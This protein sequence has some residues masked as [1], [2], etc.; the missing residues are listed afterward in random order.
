MRVNA[1]F[2]RVLA[3]SPVPL[4]LQRGGLAARLQDYSITP[5]SSILALCVM[6]LMRAA[7]ITRASGRGWALEIETFLDPVNWHRADRRV[8]F[9][10]PKKSRYS[11]GQ[12]VDCRQTDISVR[13][14]AGFAGVLT[15]SP[16]PLPLQRGGLAARLQYYRP[17]NLPGSIYRKN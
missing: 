2:A 6:L 17:G 12:I 13:V 5:V 14:N 10:G 15:L 16:V 7:S 9:L 1:G 4:P 11:I 8:P 3:L